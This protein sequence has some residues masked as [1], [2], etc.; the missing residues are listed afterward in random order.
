MSGL[1][2]HNVFCFFSIQRIERALLSILNVCSELEDVREC[3]PDVCVRVCISDTS[4]EWEVMRLV[5]PGSI[6]EE[7]LSSR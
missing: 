3:T 2:Q 4:S 5:M 6:E 1:C 7:D